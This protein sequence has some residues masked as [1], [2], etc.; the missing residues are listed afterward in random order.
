MN[1]IPNCDQGPLHKPS[2]GHRGRH[3]CHPYPEI[4]SG[5]EV[6]SMSARLFSKT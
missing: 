5:L 1:G 4:A 6:R 3:V 2:N